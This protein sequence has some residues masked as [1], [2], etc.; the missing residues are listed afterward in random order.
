L[1]TTNFI[2][3][4]FA[5]VD[6]ASRIIDAFLT[7]LKTG[8][9]GVSPHLGSSSLMLHFRE[10]ILTPETGLHIIPQEDKI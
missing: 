6:I 10:V 4:R 3:S 9:A 5:R 8:G 7:G 2:E 1:R